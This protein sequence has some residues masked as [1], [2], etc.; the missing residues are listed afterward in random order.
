M[1]P[2]ADSRAGTFRLRRPREA[3][4]NAVF[5][6]NLEVGPELRARGRDAA[7]RLGEERRRQPPYRDRRV[8]VTA[9]ETPEEA[10]YV[11]RDEGPG[12]D[13]FALPDPTDP[14]GLAAPSGRGLVLIRSF[15]DVVFHNQRGN[16]VTLIKRRR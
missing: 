11:I 15:M 14:A 16:E 3:L 5:H 13:P 2:P 12:F 9:Q 4:T 6:G 1:S 10:R 7:R 8:R